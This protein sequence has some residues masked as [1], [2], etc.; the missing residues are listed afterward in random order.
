MICSLTATEMAALIRARELSAREVMEA[1]LER[2]ERVNPQVNAIVTLLP[3]RALESAAQADEAQARGESLGPLHG[4]PIAHKDL[5]ETARIRT[6]FGSPI[7]KDN[8]PAASA[9]FVERIQRAGAITIGKTNTPEFGA[10]SQTFNRVF[11]ATRNP[12]NLSKTCG[13]SSGGAAVALACGM[14]PVADGSD[15]GGSLRNPAAFCG[16]VGLRPAPGRVAHTAR[17]FAWSTL[18]TAGPMARN[19]RDLALLLSVMAG[20]DSRCPISINEPGSKFAEPL[21]RN[22]RGTRIAWLQKLDGMVFDPLI[23]DQV[24]AQRRVFEGLGC[25]ID[26]VEPDFSGVDEA[27][28]IFRAWHFLALA[29][30]LPKDRHCELKDTIR[31]E[32]ERGLKLTASDLA[33]AELLR[34]AAWDRMRRFFEIYDYFVLPTTQVAPFDIEVPYPTEIAGVKMATYID[35]M[36][37][38]YWISM[39]ECPAISVPCGFTL[40]GLPVGLQIVGKHRDEFSVLQIAHAFELATPELRRPPQL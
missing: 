25:L 21:D 27:F 20:P 22:F 39:V 15:M 40:D 19:V 35:W 13:G 7:F 37:S 23:A 34:A 16:V 14:L 36:K 18:M 30:D 33:H 1:H 38:C 9:L 17:G 28:N 29:G 8:I 3:E 6:T 2:I 24:N 11:G 12:Y 4:L 10:G 31:W 32:I 5:A 26:E